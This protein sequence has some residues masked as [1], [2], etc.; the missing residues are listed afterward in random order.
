MKRTLLI[1]VLILGLMASMLTTAEAA[2]KKKKKKKKGPQRI[3]RT[4]EFEYT[5]PC[6]GVLQ[7]GTLTGGDPNLGGGAIT[8]GADDLFLKGVAADVTGLDVAVSINQDD[9]T[10]ANKATGEFCTETEDA[11]ALDPGMEIRVF[12]GGPCAD[13]TPSAPVTG[14]I[15]F[16]LSNLP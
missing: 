2:K 12:I 16:T 8:V 6:T 7:L 14:T 11:I 15:T 9:G 5:C 10:G 4:V 3:E 1:A 13:L